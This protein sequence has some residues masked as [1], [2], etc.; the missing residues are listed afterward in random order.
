MSVRKVERLND[1][2]DELKKNYLENEINVQKAEREADLAEGLAD[3]A[4]SVSF[5]AMCSLSRWECCF[6]FCT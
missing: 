6:F 5:I 4:E 1:R 3:R 2:L